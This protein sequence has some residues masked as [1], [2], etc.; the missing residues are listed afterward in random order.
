M[1]VPKQTVGELREQDRVSVP[2]APWATER[3]AELAINLEAAC[4]L[5]EHMINEAEALHGPSEGHRASLAVLR[6]PLKP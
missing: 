3:E 5:L 6:E 4:M 1:T 2:F